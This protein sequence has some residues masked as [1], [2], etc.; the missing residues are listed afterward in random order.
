MR[1]TFVGSFLVALL[2]GCSD[3]EPPTR[4]H[5]SGTAT[6]DGKAI[7]YGEI[8]F[9]PDGAKQNAGPQGIATI[10]AGKFDTAADGKG[11]AGGHTVIRVTGFTQQGGKLLCEHELQREL[12]RADSTQEFDVPAKGAPGPA[13]PEI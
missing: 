11:S 12:P 7:P 5:V 3:S 8:L 4:F 2:A 13:R 10:R 6:V 1:T 9:T